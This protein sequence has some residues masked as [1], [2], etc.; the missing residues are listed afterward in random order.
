MKI[1]E[2]DINELNLSEADEIQ[3]LYPSEPNW[4]SVSDETIIAL[5]KDFISEPNCATLALGQLKIRKHPLGISLAEWLLHEK[6]ADEWLKESAQEILDDYL[7]QDLS[8]GIKEVTKEVFK[9]I[10]FEYG[11]SSDG[12]TLD[13]WNQFYESPQKNSIKYLA[14]FPAKPSESRMMIVNDNVANE[15]RLFFLNEDEEENLFSK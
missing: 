6:D 1:K 15:Y 13:Y 4:Q 8:P 9:E 2:L 12:W 3:F 14:C 5:V 7:N 11:K 10:Y